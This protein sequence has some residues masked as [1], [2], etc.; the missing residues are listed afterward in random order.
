VEGNILWCFSQKEHLTKKKVPVILQGNEN[1]KQNLKRHQVLYFQKVH[2][3][4]LSHWVQR[5]FTSRHKIALLRLK[6]EH[7]DWGNSLLLCPP[8]WER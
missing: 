1:A 7:R 6:K 4:S 2:T 3:N 8:G 5:G